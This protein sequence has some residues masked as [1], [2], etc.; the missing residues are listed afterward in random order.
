M[1]E[2]G[3]RVYAE[4]LTA[5]IREK[6]DHIASIKALYENIR[7]LKSI[8]KEYPA[9]LELLAHPGIGRMEKEDILHG[10]FEGRVMQEL[11]G[12]F[13][14]LVKKGRIEWSIQILDEA[15]ISCEKYMNVGE[16]HVASGWELRQEQR[17][18]IEKRILETTTYA[19]LQM[20]Y[21]ID[22]ELMGGVVIRIGGR[23][24]DGSVKH[25]LENMTRRLEN[26]NTGDTCTGK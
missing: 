13:K 14:V 7:M 16:I 12:L 23:V 21:R 3:V 5:L 4:A 22:P 26:I 15:L 6:E 9:F 10:V 25:R 17:E 2:S 8:L 24:A 1:E 20:H 11:Y 18:R 19:S